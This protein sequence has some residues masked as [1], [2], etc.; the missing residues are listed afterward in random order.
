VEIFLPGNYPD[1]F[2]S[3]IRYFMSL[4]EITTDVEKMDLDL[5]HSFLSNESYWAK[6][7][8]IEVTKKAIENSICFAAMDENKTIGF[9]RVVTDRATFAYIGDVFVK[10]EYRGRGIGKLLMQAMIDHPELQNLRR[11]ILATRDAHGLYSKYGFTGLKFPERWMERA[12]E[13]AY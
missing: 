5:I 6:G 12:A 1:I 13:W 10:S 9:G 7:R 11:W 8:S 2:I 4:F 3:P